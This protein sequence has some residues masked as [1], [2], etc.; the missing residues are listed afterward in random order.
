MGLRL[1]LVRV[2]FLFFLIS[3]LSLRH[4]DPPVCVGILAQLLGTASLNIVSEYRIKSANEPHE[5]VVLESE[6]SKLVK[7]PAQK[8]HWFCHYG[9]WLWLR[10]SAFSDLSRAPH[11]QPSLEVSPKKFKSVCAPLRSAATTRFVKVKVMTRE[12]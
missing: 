2:R 1:V 10:R 8:C 3:F 11:L 6:L 12:R 5:R 9:S 7:T 4:S